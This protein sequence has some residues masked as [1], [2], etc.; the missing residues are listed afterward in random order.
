MVAAGFLTRDYS[1]HLKTRKRGRFSRFRLSDN[2]VRF[3]LK[4]IEPHSQEIERGR[5][6]GRPISSL[7]AW[8]SVIGL[9][10]ENLVLHNRELVWNACGLSPDDIVQDGPF[11]QTKTQQKRGC[12]IDY[13]IQTRHGPL[14]V[15][16]IKFSREKLGPEIVEDVEEKIAR[17]KLPKHTSVLPV[18]I[19]VGG[20]T[21]RLRYSNAFARIVDFTEVFT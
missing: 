17:L 5:F 1:W 10:F 3:Y 4:C 20:V 6:A 19:H 18:L 9:Q 2:Y 7:P 15:C 16:E 21:D 14:Y 13:L 8:E 11:V 12:Q